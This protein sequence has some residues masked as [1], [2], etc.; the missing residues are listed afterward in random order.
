MNNTMT[1]D[2][3]YGVSERAAVRKRRRA[4]HRHIVNRV[5]FTTFMVIV[6]L[7][8]GLISGMLFGSFD[9]EGSSRTMYKTVTVSA[10]DTLWDIASAYKPEDKEIRNYIYEIC[11][12][13][14]I[15]A[16][17]IYEGQ[18]IMIPISE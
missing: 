2:D 1:Y 7:M 10:G 14:D 16:G 18:D 8:A 4:H 17:A 6:I 11:D 15:S 3:A 5:R 12:L 13:N 9:A